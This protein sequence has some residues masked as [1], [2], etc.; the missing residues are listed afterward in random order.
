MKDPSHLDEPQDTEIHFLQGNSAIEHSLQ[1]GVGEIIPSNTL[2]LSLPGNELFS[3]FNYM[4]QRSE[5]EH[6]VFGF[7]FFFF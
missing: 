5:P 6:K 1:R 3:N 7:F 4:E 2:L